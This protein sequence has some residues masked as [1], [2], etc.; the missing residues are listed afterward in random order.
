MNL[1]V[2]LQCRALKQ[3]G[4]KDVLYSPLLIAVVK[5]LP[6]INYGVEG[7]EVGSIQVTFTN[8][9]DGW[10]PGSKWREMH[11]KKDPL[12]EIPEE[13]FCAA[14]TQ[15]DCH[16]PPRNKYNFSEVFDLTIFVAV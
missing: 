15:E 9:E 10:I 11:L 2:E 16:V 3:N 14:T 7:N 1:K 6:I 8:P 13:I 4:R 12:E 5:N